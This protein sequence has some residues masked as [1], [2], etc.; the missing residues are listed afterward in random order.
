M[1]DL[2]RYSLRFL[3][4]N[5]LERSTTCQKRQFDQYCARPI[6]GKWREIRYKLILVINRKLYTGFRLVSVTMTLNDPERRNDRR[7]V[8]NR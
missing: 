4:T 2:W 1:I 7:L 5:L 6:S 8:C 3:R